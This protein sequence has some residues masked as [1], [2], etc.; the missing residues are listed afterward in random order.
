ME[1]N[2]IMKDGKPYRVTSYSVDFG[3]KNG[4]ARVT[5]Y[6][7]CIS[8]AAQQ[9]RREAIVRKCEELIRRGWMV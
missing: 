9:R 2:I 3:P 4:V 1:D 8:E 7:P 5:V 6:D